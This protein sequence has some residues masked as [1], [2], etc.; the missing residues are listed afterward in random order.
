MNTSAK[1]EKMYLI[2]KVNINRIYKN[3]NIQNKS[4]KFIL[5]FLIILFFDGFY[6]LKNKIYTR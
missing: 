4:I 6:N 5:F 3:K 1:L 2:C